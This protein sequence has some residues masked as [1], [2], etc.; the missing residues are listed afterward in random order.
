MTLISIR[1]S[2]EGFSSDP[3]D[4]RTRFLHTK[5]PRSRS[6]RGH[7]MWPHTAVTT[8]EFPTPGEYF[9]PLQIPW[10]LRPLQVNSGRGAAPHFRDTPGSSPI[11]A[12]H[13]GK[14]PG[15]AGLGCGS[16]KPGPAAAATNGP[17]IP[18]N[19]INSAPVGPGVSI[20]LKYS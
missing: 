8:P 14:L 12:C 5:A 20:L 15:S 10:I 4:N 18:R 6:R 9:K 2:R 3:K 1:E 16:T 17:E 19:S 11:S 13:P 7:S